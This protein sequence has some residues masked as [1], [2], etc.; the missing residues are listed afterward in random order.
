MS[1]DT[2]HFA[3]KRTFLAWM[4]TGISL[5]GFGF[6]IAKFVIF[7]HALENKPTS[8]FSTSLIA[9]EVMIIVGII[10]I[11][12]GFYEYYSTEKDIDNNKYYSRTTELFVFTAIIIGMA[13]LLLLFII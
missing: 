7:L 11:G 5:M 12:Y 13:I 1:S 2:D 9:G 3:N 8:S 10:T 6:V 4:R